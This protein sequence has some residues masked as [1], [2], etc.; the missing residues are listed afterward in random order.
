ML[1]VIQNHWL[2]G[3][4]IFFMP[5]IFI[6]FL[7][8]HMAYGQV[9]A[10]FEA[11]QDIP[12]VARLSD[13]EALPPGQV[14]MLRGRIAEASCA[15][16]MLSSCRRPPAGSDLIIYRERP[17]KGR[18]VRFQET[19]ELVFPQFV[20]ALPDGQLL[21]MPSLT[22]EPVIQHELHRVSGGDRQRTGFRAGDL[23]TVQGQWQPEPGTT[24]ALIEVTGMTGAGKQSLMQE[25]QDAFRQVGWVR[26]SLGLFTLLSILLLVVHLRQA[27]SNRDSNSHEAV[28][29]K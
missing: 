25:W 11:Y 7:G 20:L 12:E 1:R 28:P 29:R 27:K 22:R 9:K 10:K 3:A 15:S 2:T 13:L 17:A 14:V 24:P 26:N 8:S 19:F 5:V 23:V 16:A 4:M 21:I 18:E 6:F